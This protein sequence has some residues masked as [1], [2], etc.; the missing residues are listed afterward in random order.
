MISDKRNSFTLKYENFK[1]VR[2]GIEAY[3]QELKLPQNEI[4]NGLLMIEEIFLR[5]RRV[6]KDFQAE[7]KIK[8]R[9]GN[10]LIVMQSEGEPYD[11]LESLN[12]WDDNEE[13]YY[14]TIIRSYFNGDSLF[15][16]SCYSRE[17]FPDAIF[18]KDNKFSSDTGLNGK[19]YGNNALY[20]ELLH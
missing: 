20:N 6:Q 9:F 5:F 4:M 13:N 18:K 7:I 10:V 2:S 1:E 17:N 11:P 12:E 15:N 19:Q 16:G 14:N 3:L 8:K